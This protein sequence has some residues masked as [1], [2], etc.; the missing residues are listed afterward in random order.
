MRIS[1]QSSFEPMARTATKSL[2]PGIHHARVVAVAAQKGGV[3]KTTTTVCLAAAWARFHRLRVLV[4]DL[5]PQ[6]HVNVALRDQVRVGGGAISDV[7]ADPARY[8][9]AEIAT[10]TH[11]DGLDITPAD[12]GLI[13]VEDR[14]ASRIG[15]ELVLR[16]ALEVTRTHYDL[17]LLDC[18]PNIGSLTVN[19]LVAAD[20]VLIPCA[21]SALAVSGVSGLLNAVGDVRDQLH[22]TLAVLGLVLTMV[23]GRNARTNGAIFDLVR[24]NWSDILVPVQI[25]VSTSLSAA[26]L[27]G[28]DVFDVEPESR[29]AQQYRALA[30]NLLTRM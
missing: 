8:E 22:P 3:G 6:A 10:T 16:K 5:D 24:E 11:I 13:R 28:R 30:D 26:Q 1:L 20:S 2:Q 14:L 21:A 25:G 12:P 15:K 23:D 27:A 7:L 18:P 19:A 4:V 29:G 9:I 17:I